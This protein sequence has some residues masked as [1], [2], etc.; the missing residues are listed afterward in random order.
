MLSQ[1]ARVK[2]NQCAVRHMFGRRFLGLLS[3]TFLILM[4]EITSVQAGPILVTDH[5]KVEASSFDGF[6]T[7]N[8]PVISEA[9]D[10]SA[11]SDTVTSFD[12]LTDGRT[13]GAE[14][15]QNTTI[16]FTS[17]TIN[18]GVI[19]TSGGAVANWGDD[20]PG[21]GRDPRGEA[22]SEFTV[23]FDVDQTTSFALSG[24]IDTVADNSNVSCTS[25]SVTS[26]SGATFDVADG[27]GC[28]SSGQSVDES[29]TLA[30]GRY[31]FSIIAH[32]IADNPN[33][34]GGDAQASFE[35]ILV[36]GCTI[37]GTTGDDVIAWDKWRRHHL[38]AWR[39]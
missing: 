22:K 35:L 24:S 4:G 3:I 38:W 6:G 23:T 7:T 37:V 34:T 21:D 32:A 27:P 20:D 36:L 10:V 8:P 19:E 13:A 15:T 12:D 11:F 39:I 30:P 28:G 18:F 25:V 17:T 14:A 2:T 16:D 9:S 29:G 33:E 5:A 26:P 31:T 1:K